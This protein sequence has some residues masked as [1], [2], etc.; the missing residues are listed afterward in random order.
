M[1]IG[2]ILKN[3]WKY[4][5]TIRNFG[6]NGFVFFFGGSKELS[7]AP[8][9]NKSI[10]YVIKIF[11]NHFH[12]FWNQG[13]KIQSH[14]ELTVTHTNKKFGN[15]LLLLVKSEDEGK[16]FNCIGRFS[17]SKIKVLSIVLKVPTSQKY[18]QVLKYF[19]ELKTVSR[20]LRE[21]CWS[22][23]KNCFE[24]LDEK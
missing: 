9:D 18:V 13:R 8:S 23:Q 11:E 10:A 3:S 20:K 21:S 16:P 17:C 14:F 22:A 24:A 4:L 7:R 12:E 15:E 5:G 1:N 6:N 2:K 19:N